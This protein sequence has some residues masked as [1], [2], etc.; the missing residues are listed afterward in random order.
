MNDFAIYNTQ[1]L[2]MD[3]FN[4]RNQGKTQLKIFLIRR[5]AKCLY[6]ISHAFFRLVPISLRM[7]INTRKAGTMRWVSH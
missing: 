2:L 1:S 5:H 3:F 7:T 4:C 6:I